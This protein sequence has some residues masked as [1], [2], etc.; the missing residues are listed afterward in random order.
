M[1]KLLLLFATCAT[2]LSANAQTTP[3][4]SAIGTPS[5]TRPAGAWY[6][7]VSKNFNAL[8]GDQAVLICPAGDCNEWT[9]SLTGQLS[10]SIS[11][12]GG[13]TIQGV[14]ST[15][16]PNLVSGTYY[17]RPTFT[18]GTEVQRE[19]G[20]VLPGG[21]Q[22]TD[23]KGDFYGAGVFNVQKGF[24]YHNG[25][26][27]GYNPYAVYA[28]KTL[29]TTSAY[30]PVVV[31]AVGNYMEKPAKP[32]TI[33]KA[34]AVC[35]LNGYTAGTFT[36][37]VYK[38]T[39]DFTKQHDQN[40]TD[41]CLDAITLGDVIAETTLSATDANITTYTDGSGVAWTYLPFDFGK[42]ITI[43]DAIVIQISGFDTYSKENDHYPQMYMFTQATPNTA[44]KDNY[45]YA[46]LD[47]TNNTSGETSEHNLPTSIIAWQN[48]DGDYLVDDNAYAIFVDAEYQEPTAITDVKTVN[49][50][51]HEYYDLMGRRISQPVSGQL[52]IDSQD[53]KTHLAR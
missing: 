40:N 49:N 5:Y 53:R 37:K 28:L 45:S 6:S 17:T 43:D 29:F 20:V 42:T 35:F 23:E 52:Y 47:L 7:G 46:W 1:K 34:G 50:G 39:K 9:T 41:A 51:K 18:V 8:E 22:L 27:S 2:L 48:N 19:A 16:S 21:G 10:W 24:T 32:Y 12:I 13:N 26:L 38:A 44:V 15:F 30:A 36:M 11:A 14:G 33:S 4:S 3:S 25:M 31:K